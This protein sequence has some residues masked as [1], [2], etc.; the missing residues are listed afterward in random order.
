[1]RL[2][3]ID[4]RRRAQVGR[5]SEARR[6]W[7]R[8]GVGGEA[9]LL[10][11]ACTTGVRFHPWRAGVQVEPGIRIPLTPVAERVSAAVVVVTA[12]AMVVTVVAT[13]KTAAA[14]IS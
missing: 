3:V 2:C 14:A 1:M 7:W 9:G 12:A 4:V 13:I 6:R 5:T 10:N 11:E 8:S